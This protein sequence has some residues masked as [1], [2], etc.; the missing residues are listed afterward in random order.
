MLMFIYLLILA[1]APL[2]LGKSNRQR[3]NREAKKPMECVA[4][5]CLPSDYNPL[6][7][8]SS[9]RQDVQINLEVGRNFIPQHSDA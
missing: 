1:Q 6:E 4:D 3:H 7:L 2:L 8:P 5:Y 9:E